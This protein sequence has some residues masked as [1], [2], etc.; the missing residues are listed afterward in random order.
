M[1]AQNQIVRQIIE[2]EYPIDKW[3]LNKIEKGEMTMAEY[4]KKKIG[5]MIE[6]REKDLKDVT[7][8]LNNL[9]MLHDLCDELFP[10]TDGLGE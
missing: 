9:N 6:Y 1:K 2:A 5:N 3:D 7:E 8:K 10:V 4:Y